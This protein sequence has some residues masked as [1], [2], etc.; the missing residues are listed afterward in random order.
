[1]VVLPQQIQ[2]GRMRRRDRK[3]LSI[4]GALKATRR[5]RKGP[6]NDPPDPVPPVQ[7]LPG[8][9]ANPVEILKRYDVLMGS[10]LKHRIRRGVY[11][12]TAGPD[13]FLAQLLDDFGARSR[14]IS[15]HLATDSLLE[16]IQ[17]PG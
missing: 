5:T 13:V 1:K 12:R 7:Q 2:E 4:L 15:Q 16:G 14:L 8:Y 3:I 9:S 11:D 6:S 10:D 17:D